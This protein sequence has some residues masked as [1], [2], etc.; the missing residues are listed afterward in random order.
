MNGVVYIAGPYAAPTEEE[1]R[2][3]VRRIGELSRFALSLGF[4]PVSVH[5]A[6]EAGHLGDDSD[7]EARAR[8]LN[9][10]CEIV[11]AVARA[12]GHFF[13]IR[14]DDR[15]YSEGTY[16]ERDTFLTYATFGVHFVRRTWA[17]WQEAIARGS[18]W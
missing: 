15:R 13:A 4:A 16:L 11:S 6:I 17:E 18:L 9:A 8:G 5:A 14:R 3:N 1:R 7:P 12:D 2:E 10:A